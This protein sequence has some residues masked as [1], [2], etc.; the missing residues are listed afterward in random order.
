MQLRTIPNYLSTFD[1]LQYLDARNNNIST[2]NKD[3]LQLIDR[4]KMENYFAGNH[5]VCGKHKELDC[6]PL[7]SSYCW[8]RNSANDG[9]CATECNSKECNFDGGDCI[10]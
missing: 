2:I 4:N 7:C 6:E 1:R 8:S 3:L 5:I 9:Y 10:E